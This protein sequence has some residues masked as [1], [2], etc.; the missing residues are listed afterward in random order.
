VSSDPPAER[1]TLAVVEIPGTV[2]SSPTPWQGRA[3]ADSLGVDLAVSSRE[4]MGGSPALA[5]GGPLSG[6]VGVFALHSASRL[7]A[8]IAIL[9]LQRTSVASC[10]EPLPHRK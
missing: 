4:E 5:R 10:F 8:R 3:R 9:A 2:S 1:C 7:A 6:L